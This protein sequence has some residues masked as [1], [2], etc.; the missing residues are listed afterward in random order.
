MDLIDLSS[1]EI[2]CVVRNYVVT[3][4]ILM[5]LR[6]W[7]WSLACIKLNFYTENS[8]SKTESLFPLPSFRFNL[9]TF[10]MQNATFMNTGG[11]IWAR[12][13][14]IAFI[15][16]TTNNL[17]RAPAPAAA[18]RRKCMKPPWNGNGRGKGN[19]THSSSHFHL[20]AVVAVVAVVVDAVFFL[21][22]RTRR[23]H[24]FPSCNRSYLR[25]CSSRL[26]I[27]FPLKLLKNFFGFS[28]VIILTSLKVKFHLKIGAQTI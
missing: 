26:K 24:I 9:F 21:S 4:S 1:V 17:P 28:Y 11:H 7:T 16:N 6:Q 15:F 2:R 3:I 22:F 14:I 12:H 20:C 5:A 19:G 23:A 8:H 13:Q 27:G 10:Y 18:A 25:W